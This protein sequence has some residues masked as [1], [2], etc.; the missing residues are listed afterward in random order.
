MWYPFE[1]LIEKKKQEIEEHNKF[2]QTRVIAVKNE[3]KLLTDKASKIASKDDDEDRERAKRLDDKCP[4]CRSENV[5]DRIKRQQGSIDGSIDGE[6]NHFLFFGHG[7]ISGK[8]KGELDTNE[9]NKCNDCGHEWKK[10]ERDYT[11]TSD[12]IK[13][14]VQ[15]VYYL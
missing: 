1:N 2:I 15:H 4:E 9:V 6:Y 7:S 13:K 10:Y 5:N 3:I 12:I 11:W 8:V 14:K